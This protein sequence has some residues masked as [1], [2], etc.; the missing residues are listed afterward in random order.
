MLTTEDVKDSIESFL[1][2]GKKLSLP[3][4][5][6][7]YTNSKSSFLKTGQVSIQDIPQILSQNG[8]DVPNEDIVTYENLFK[9][10]LLFPAE[11]VENTELQMFQVK[12]AMM[13]R[14]SFLSSV[15]QC[16]HGHYK[17]L[18]SC[19]TIQELIYELE[20]ELNF[21]IEEATVESSHSESPVNDTFDFSSFSSFS[22]EGGMDNRNGFQ[23]QQQFVAQQVTT[24]TEKA[25]PIIRFLAQVRKMGMDVL[26]P[27]STHDKVR[28][29]KIL[30]IIFEN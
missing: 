5:L 17:G 21:R 13:H 8:I 26:F 9:E 3:G 28:I 14:D 23:H 22:F 1:L 11:V 2:Q 12:P 6:A 4:I 24:E 16:L 15:V 18:E 20:T 7:I 25:E 29:E 10:T 30:I 27:Q 19:S